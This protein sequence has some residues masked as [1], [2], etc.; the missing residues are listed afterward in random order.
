MNLD[1][2][3]FQ[4]GNIVDPATGVQSVT[5]LNTDNTDPANP[6][7]NI[8]VDGTT[9][10]G[11]GTP[12]DPLVSVTNNTGSITYYL[13][14]SVTETPYKQFS[15][16][17]TT[18]VEQVVPLTVLGGATTIIGEFQTP[19]GVP[20][21]TQIV[22]GLWSFYLHFNASSS[23]QNWI[24]RPTVWKRDLGGI[25]TLLFTSDPVI[26]TNMNVT[27][28]MYTS[29]GVF[30]ATTLLTTDRLVVR[31][32][33]QNTTGVSQ[34]V[35]F[36]T[37]G[38]QH[39]SVSTTTLNP[40]YNPSAVLSVTG[41]APVVS[42]GGTT[43]AISIPQATGAIDGYLSSSDFA[44]FNA[45]VGGSGTTNY[46]S[47]FT[48]TGTIGNSQ[49]QDNGANI[50]VNGAIVSAYKFAVYSTTP[51]ENYN[52]YGNTT[53]NGATGITGVNQG[54]GALTNY[55]ASASAQNSTTKNIGIYSSADGPSTENIG[56]QFVALSATNNY[57]LQLKDGTEG[58]GKVL[59]SMTS[60]GKAQ[61]VA[62][63]SASGVFGIANTSGV[64]TFYATLILAMASATSGQTIEMF[65]DYT[66]TSGG[67][68]LKNGVNINGNSHTYTLNK[69]GLNNTLSDGGVFVDCS[70]D[71]IKIVRTGGTASTSDNSC[72]AIT[73]PSNIKTTAIFSSAGGL[74]IYMNNANCYLSGGKSYVIN[75]S[76]VYVTLGNLSNHYV[77]LNSNSAS[78]YGIYCISGSLLNCHGVSKG[79]DW[80]NIISNSGTATNCS[81][82]ATAAGGY[83]S[84]FY[85]NGIAL[86]CSGY[87]I[88]TAG[89]GNGGRA[90]NCSGYS[91]ASNGF[92][93]NAAPIS[94]NC[95]GYS[96]S[97]VGLGG[98]N[99]QYIGCSGYSTG[100]YGISISNGNDG[101]VHVLNCT[102]MSTASSGATFNYS[103]NN[104]GVKNCTIKT[105]YSSALGHGIVLGTANNS[106]SGCNI[107][108]ASSSANC[109]YKS[110]VGTVKYASNTFEGATTAV[111]ANITQGVTNTHDN[112]G[113]I[114]M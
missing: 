4:G 76:G 14:Q 112:Q 66:E 114:L 59:T 8:S 77:E 42:S 13:N 57:S 65:S 39:Y 69:T 63:T 75:Y 9:I 17:V 23:G 15:S 36:R 46:L 35:N 79:P 92:A 91:T 29:D 48:G 62:P 74:C 87:S 41:T 95:S 106:V 60:D 94:I 47:K 51:G 98:Y 96:V 32:S 78:H 73:G 26:V 30:P 105:T 2:F 71:D 88:N 20:A 84:A 72:L 49:T 97:G 27:T 90:E 83:G 85:N 70:I 102:A 33:M 67:V 31:I 64:Y 99:G 6:I 24:I 86:N 56:G 11:S 7:V 93:A 3:G 50:A 5:G 37:E 1:S 101:Q 100:N 12:L 38:S 45:K 80:S 58:V 18:A 107:T 68:A 61:W 53:V 10:T 113:N 34:T 40:A 52:I 28:E 109:I 81:A 25:E 104:G 54:V 21:S 111:N 19:V 44:V 108:V 110:A 55:G 16:V 82:I 89:F 43:P 103:P 22:A